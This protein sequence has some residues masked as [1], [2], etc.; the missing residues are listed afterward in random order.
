MRN[1]DIDVEVEVGNSSNFVNFT[2][3]LTGQQQ[4]DIG[5]VSYRKKRLEKLSV[6]VPTQ[7]NMNVLLRLPYSFIVADFSLTTPVISGNQTIVAST[8]ECSLCQLPL[9]SEQ[10]VNSHSRKITVHGLTVHQCLVCPY[11]STQKTIMRKH[12]HNRTE[13]KAY[14][15]S[16]CP[17]KSNYLRSFKRHM[18]KL[19]RCECLVVS[20]FDEL[21]EPVK[22]SVCEFSLF[23]LLPFHTAPIRRHPSCIELI[24]QQKHVNCASL[25]SDLWSVTTPTYSVSNRLVLA[26]TNVDCVPTFHQNIKA[27]EAM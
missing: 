11:K 8:K 22:F 20:V 16:R 25:H 18:K 26:C 19:H 10:C 9:G 23:Q 4:K 5:T 17:F 3:C 21:F 24:P 1:L 7:G 27:P 15:C 12:I 6:S 13:Y 14:Q 2:C